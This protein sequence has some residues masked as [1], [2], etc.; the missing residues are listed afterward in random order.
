MGD[1]SLTERANICGS[2][3]RAV[4]HHDPGADLLPLFTVGYAGNPDVP[5]IR[6]L[7]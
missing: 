1:L 6:M 3:A 7:E 5:D 4:V 2:E